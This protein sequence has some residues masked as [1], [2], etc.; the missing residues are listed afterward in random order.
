VYLDEEYY[1]LLYN[2]DIYKFGLKVEKEVSELIVK[3]INDRMVKRAKQKVMALLKSMNRT[4]AELKSKLALAGYREAAI[5]EAI[6][7]VKSYHYIDDSKYAASFI[8]LKK[9]NKSR[10]Q[11]IGELKQ[12]GVS[13][14]E[15]E[16]ALTTE[17]DNEEE[18]IQREI[19]KKVKDVDSLSRE[20]KQKLAAKL[21]RKGYGMDLIKSFVKLEY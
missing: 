7:Y 1:F 20:E 11:I 17:Y 13:D 18:A 12:K 16:E 21:Y 15:I 10:R 6:E 9:Q 5:V 19:Q 14:E 8:R 4:E 3:E 2:S